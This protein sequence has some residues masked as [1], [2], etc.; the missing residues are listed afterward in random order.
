MS[1]I[2]VPN[3]RNTKFYLYDHQNIS[4]SE[5]FTGLNQYN[6]MFFSLGYSRGLKQFQALY[7]VLLIS[8]SLDFQVERFQEQP[9]LICIDP[10]AWWALAFKIELF[11]LPCSYVSYVQ[12]IYSVPNASK[13]FLKCLC[14][15]LNVS[16]TYVALNYF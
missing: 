11:V 15:T 5:G 10:W 13:H 9:I 1:H 7:F 16:L 8:F 14:T 12:A 3:N 4:K 6:N 2:G